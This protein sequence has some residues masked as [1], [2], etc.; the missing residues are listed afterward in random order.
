MKRAMSDERQ[1]LLVEHFPT[2]SSLNTSN[3]MRC[4]HVT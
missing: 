3:A 4:A 1:V 2:S